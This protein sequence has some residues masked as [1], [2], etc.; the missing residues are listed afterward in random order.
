[1]EHPSK[2]L[3][4]LTGKTASGKD[5]VM[6][7]L[8]SRFP[9]F[10]RIVTTASRKKRHGEKDGVDYNFISEQD[11]KLKIDRQEFIEYV[12]YGGNLYGTEK[13]QIIKN[14]DHNLIWRIDPSRAG[15]IREFIKSAFDQKMSQDLLKRILVIYLTVDDAVVLER[16][17]KRGLSSA[18]I[19][20]RMQ[21]DAKFWQEF[22]DNYDCV[23]ENVSG[24]LGE[25]VNQV[26]SLISKRLKPGKPW[27]YF[28]LQV[29]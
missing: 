29:K 11:F 6:A 2:L 16:L 9:E 22:K 27:D 15:K 28:P 7:K 25:T 26:C 18:E 13:I 4:V 8:L 24:K 19:E 12:E 1:M 17:K 14:L 3:I 5:T 23:I 20:K 10:K 21:E